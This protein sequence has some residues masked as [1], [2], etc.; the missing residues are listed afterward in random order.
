MFLRSL[1]QGL[2]LQRYNTPPKDILDLGC[3]S[4]LWIV[5]A[6]QHWPVR[7][8]CV[9]YQQGS[10]HAPQSSNFIGYDCLKVQ[11]DLKALS[12]CQPGLEDLARR[13]KWVHG[14]L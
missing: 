2:T 7:I 5:D 9:S 12:A 13:V 4:G 6:A 11:P 1:S 3:G 8:R 10:D 14:N